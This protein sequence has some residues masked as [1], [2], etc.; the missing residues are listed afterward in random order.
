MHGH[1]PSLAG[2][3]SRWFTQVSAGV[4]V[5]KVSARVSQEVLGFLKNEK[6]DSLTWIETSNTEQ[7]FRV[8]ILGEPRY[9]TEDFDGLPLMIRR[10]KKE[11]EPS[12]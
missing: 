9:M 10:K 8:Q 5:G 12:I 6:Y 11:A 3:L 7:G 4:F 1:L 2:K